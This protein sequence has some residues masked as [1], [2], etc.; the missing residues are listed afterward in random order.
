MFLGFKLSVF[1][2]GMTNKGQNPFRILRRILPLK[3]NCTFLCKFLKTMK[4]FYAMLSRNIDNVQI[5]INSDVT[6][7]YFQD[8]TVRID[9]GF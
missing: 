9:H 7:V 1:Q 6:K 5:I 4:I 8:V 3:T 2:G